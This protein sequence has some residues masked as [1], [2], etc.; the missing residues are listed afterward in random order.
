[1]DVGEARLAIDYGT[2]STVAVL[3]WPDG[4]W[5]P[6]L[7][8]GMV[9]L[10][11]AVYAHPDGR[12]LTGGE[13]WQ[14]AL[15]APEYVEPYPKQRIR[16]ATI[17]LGSRKVDVLDLV[18]ATLRRVGDE[19][20]RLAG[21]PPS[22][23]RLVTPAGWGPR[24]RTLLRQAAHRAGIPAPT[25]VEA[26]VAAAHHLLAGGVPVAQGSCLAVCDFGAGF[27]ATVL[28]RTQDGFEVLATIADA[29]AAGDRIEHGLAEYLASTLPAGPAQTMSG[30][31]RLPLLVSAR[32]AVQ[33]LSTAAAVAVPLPAPHPPVVLTTTQVESVARPVLER[34]V[35][36]TRQTIEAADVT[37]D[38]LTGV[39]CI[40][41]LAPMPLAARLLHE[42]TGLSPTVVTD[43]HLAA[44]RGA[45]RAVGPAG[46]TQPAAS[47][48]PPLP[49]ARKAVALLLPGIASLGLLSQALATA[50]DT[51]SGPY[52]Y[53]IV[54]WGQLAM[55]AVLALLT[56]LGGTTLAA[57]VLPRLD[58]TAAAEAG[59]PHA[60]SG[61]VGTGLVAAAAVG[62]AI[63]G[64]YAITGAVYFDEDIGPFVRW[65][66][67]PAV[68]V[69]A[70]AAATGLLTTRLRRPP[71]GGWH[72][73]LSFPTGSTVCAAAGMALV[74]A[75]MSTRVP[76]SFGLLVD[77][78]ARVGGLLLGIGAVLALVARPI[79]RVIV[80]APA[81][82]FTTAIVSAATTGILGIIY[83]SAAAVWWV[84]CLWSLAYLPGSR[85]VGPLSPVPRR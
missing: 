36:V 48:S 62:L 34:A 59:T 77:A 70:V 68:P 63:A 65:A 19:A 38:Q 74:Q 69:A 39:Y 42:Q 46:G 17:E 33:A 82:V 45:A 49:P 32:T 29:D 5:T 4:R 9:L 20:T 75:A 55:A 24:R 61:Q 73:W 3:A 53:V 85:R 83:T 18:A 58:R 8:D 50:E 43:A 37:P 66:V 22:D 60:D 15:A 72:A 84:R 28:R 13:A 57:A 27:E 41:A 52:A 64:V 79:H 54:N 30:S 76:P 1:M 51:G 71:A 21:A 67:L 6:L 40:G 56:C 78:G 11:S 25:L 80:G 47:A 31:D 44:V 2:A 10:P 35:Q 14:H 7:F 12:L 23:V 26:P 16:E 81:A